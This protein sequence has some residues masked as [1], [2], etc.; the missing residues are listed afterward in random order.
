MYEDEKTNTFIIFVLS[1]PGVACN[2]ISYHSDYT[3]IIISEGYIRY[4]NIQL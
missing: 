1:V 3:V 2:V 4:V